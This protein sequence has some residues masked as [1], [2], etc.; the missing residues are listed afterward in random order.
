[1]VAFACN[2]CPQHAALASGG[3]PMW[4]EVLERNAATESERLTEDCGFRIMP[5][6]L[7]EVMRMAHRAAAQSAQ[8]R[9][10]IR[11]SLNGAVAT[12]RGF[13][14][15]AAL[16][17][18]RGKSAA[19][20]SSSHDVFGQPQHLGSEDRGVHQQP[21]GGPNDA[22]A[23]HV[24]IGGATRVGGGLHHVGLDGRESD[25]VD[26]DRLGEADGDGRGLSDG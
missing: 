13:A 11:E 8:S 26:R 19:A 16:A 12:S 22:A 15:A 23:D 18:G 5:R 4:W 3:C 6:Y 20:I 21:A 7:T 1:M 10:D 24:A 2:K 9:E 25:L 17:G 14:I